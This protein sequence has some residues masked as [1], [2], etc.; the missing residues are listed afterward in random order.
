MSASDRDKKD[1][2]G[3]RNK[4]NLLAIKGAVV[5]GPPQFL[6]L[7]YGLGSGFY[8]RIA[9]LRVYKG[10][11]HVQRKSF[12]HGIRKSYEEIH[13]IVDDLSVRLGGVGDE[14]L[15]SSESSPKYFEFTPIEMHAITERLRL[16]EPT[17]PG[18]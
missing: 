5:S 1:V 3:Y 12:D 11:I 15:T 18:K 13:S 17:A 2:L 4:E 10:P 9:S 14:W 8:K 16:P 6:E 7:T